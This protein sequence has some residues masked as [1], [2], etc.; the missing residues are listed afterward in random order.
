MRHFTSPSF[1]QAYGKLPSNLRN[2]ANSCFGKLKQNPRYLSLHL[3]KAG[4]YWSIRIGRKHRAI[5]A[6]VDLGV[7]WF[8]IGT[9]DEYEQMI[10]QP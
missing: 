4:L 8:W 7:L 10:K 2:P 3:K 5:G 9:H 6:E 1:W